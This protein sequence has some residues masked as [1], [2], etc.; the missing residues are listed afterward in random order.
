MQFGAPMHKIDEQLLACAHFF[1]VKAQF[2]L[3][4][5]VVIVIFTHDDGSPV[6]THFIQ[7][8]Q[9]LSLSQL[10]QTH[11]VYTQV[12]EKQSLTATDGIAELDRIMQHPHTYGYFWKLLFAFTAG[13]VIAPM[14]FSGSIAD[15]LISGSLSC[16]VQAIQLAGDGD[17]LFVGTME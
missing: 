15:G 3:L 4:N 7:R 6:Q 1:Q 9:G 10:R 2:V 14:G 8:P 17:T 13:G 11:A 12:V 5:T 16:A